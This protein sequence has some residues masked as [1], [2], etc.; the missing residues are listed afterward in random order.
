MLTN[1]AWI[2]CV[3]EWFSSL[4]LK[5]SPHNREL[6]IATVTSNVNNIIFQRNAFIRLNICWCSIRASVFKFILSGILM[7]VSWILKNK[8][9]YTARLRRIKQKQVGNCF[10]LMMDK[11]GELNS[12]PIYFCCFDLWFSSVYYWIALYT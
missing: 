9:W 6:I 1:K 12:I 8:S 5:N 7:S 4:K 3:D 2:K 10:D 11:W